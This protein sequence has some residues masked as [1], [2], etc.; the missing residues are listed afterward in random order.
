VIES[1]WLEGGRA[2]GRANRRRSLPPG[3]RQES[4]SPR[5]AVTECILATL[6]ELTVEAAAGSWR[7][8]DGAAAS[9]LEC[10]FGG[11]VA[12]LQDLS[13]KHFTMMVSSRRWE[14]R[15]LSVRVA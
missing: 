11:L 1:A 9:P 14:M 5:R 2:S 8:A 13:V 4:A 12:P 10:S 7:K 15:G 3:L 6:P